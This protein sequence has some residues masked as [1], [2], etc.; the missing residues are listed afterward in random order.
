MC[1]QKKTLEAEKVFFS[2]YNEQKKS[3][4]DHKAIS[5]I[6]A[7]T[8][9]TSKK[10]NSI[11]K[12]YLREVKNSKEKNNEIAK[13]FLKKL[14]AVSNET[15]KILGSQINFI[16]QTNKFNKEIKDFIGVEKIKNNI[17]KNPQKILSHIK[18]RIDYTRKNCNPN[19]LVIEYKWIKNGE[20]TFDQISDACKKSDIS[21]SQ[22]ELYSFEDLTQFC[23]IASTGAFSS[24][25]SI[26]IQGSKVGDQNI[27]K[28]A[29][30]LDKFPSL[31]TLTL[32]YV[33]MTGEGLQELT[34]KLPE[35][36]R[37]LDISE[38]H[39]IGYKGFEKF[40]EIVTK[41][42][43]LKFL[44]E[45]NIKNVN[46]ENEGLKLLSSLGESFDYLSL[47]NLESNSITVLSPLFS[48]NPKKAYFDNLQKLILFGNR[49]TTQ[50]MKDF[51]DFVNKGG[52]KY[53]KYFFASSRSG[54]FEE[55]IQ[56]EIIKYLGQS[57]VKYIAKI[58]LSKKKLEKALLYDIE[59][60]KNKNSDIAHKKAIIER[61]TAKNGIYSDIL[62]NNMRKEMLHLKSN[63]LEE[64]NKC[65]EK[66][67]FAL[68]KLYKNK[69]LEEKYDTNI[70]EEIKDFSGDI[71]IFEAYTHLDQ[72]PII[73]QASYM[74]QEE[75]IEMKESSI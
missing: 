34:R 62:P 42:E 58:D 56:N 52:F 54:S 32:R 14:E 59:K 40:V 27:I 74:E 10:F 18:E 41:Q 51:N 65:S 13:T 5:D 64:Y 25:S 45:L 47:H 46:L 72:K 33:F 2:K 8:S 43:K 53:L 68:I 16:E 35:K 1:N 28:F 15:K 70:F 19:K 61:I 57:N 49:I 21:F 66:A 69:A 44:E 29:N 60:V 7:N 39:K 36:L 17:D 20:L 63:I 26:K 37:K 6:F 12:W 48:Y 50:S 11:K 9:F 73:A 3:D 4:Y 38:N 30:I 67:F 22:L 75:Y 71:P 23:N 31:E 55:K 24:I